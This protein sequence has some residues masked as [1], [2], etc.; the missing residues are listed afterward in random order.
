MKKNIYSLI[1]GIA[2]LVLMTVAVSCSREPVLDTTEKGDPLMISP[3]LVDLKSNVFTS[4]A[5]DT[6]NDAQ[7][8]ENKVN[9]LDVFFFKTSDYSF[10]K[11]YHITTEGGMVSYGGKEGYLLTHDW[12]KDGFAKNTAYTVL[13]IANST[14]ET[15]TS[16]T[17]DS[18]ITLA[19]LK[20]LYVEDADIYKRQGSEDN[21]TYTTSKAFLMNAQ[22]DWSITTSG[23][24]LVNDNTISLERAAVKFI[25]D[26]SLS[27]GFAERLA[28]DHKKYGQPSWK[29]VNF[30]SRAA[31][32]PGGTVP[33]DKLVTRGSGKY[34]AVVPGEQ[35]GHYTIVT[36][37][38]PQSW[39]R[40]TIPSEAPSILLSFPEIDE[41]DDPEN[42]A[43]ASYHY[44][45][46]PLCQTP[47]TGTATTVRN[48]LYKV[49]AIISSHGSSEAITASSLDV[50]YEVMPWGA[51]SS[52][53][54]EAEALDYLV[55]TPTKIS[56]KGEQANSATIKY[57]AS[58]NVIIKE[59]SI[60]AY[61][62]DKTGAEVEV[63]NDFSVG[64]P[65]N[66]TVQISSTMPSNGTFRTLEFTLQLENRDLE[67]IIQIRHYPTDFIT[68]LVGSYSTYDLD[69]WAKPGISGY[70][71]S[72]L[73]GTFQFK[74]ITIP[75]SGSN[76]S[77]T[78][79]WSIEPGFMPKY[80]TTTDD[81]QYSM[82]NITAIY[83]L[84]PNG[85]TSRHL[86]NGTTYVDY[87]NNRMY[88]LQLTSAS[89][90]YIIGYPRLSSATQT[91][92]GETITYH[93]SN[94]NV[95]SPA[96]MLCS[97]LGN[98]NG[99]TSSFINAALHCALYKEVTVDGVEY[100]GW[101][102]PTKQ[103]IN[104]MLEKQG[105]TN[106][107]SDII[108]RILPSKYYWTLDG[109][110]A[111]NPSTTDSSDNTYT[112]CVRDLTPEELAAI[113]QFE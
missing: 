9:R 56:L 112:R 99:K 3:A 79:K 25:A 8:N 71:N 35:T 29:Y 80:Y 51:T 43:K 82:N 33:T 6:P 46:I 13:V 22:V 44:Y 68:S 59:G 81:P 28:T 92:S 20:A 5:D 102:L 49:K 62:I 63:T 103:E 54:V 93:S 64:T 113:N 78:Q 57:Y 105:T 41:D 21:E 60:R 36:Y 91:I 17:D 15:I 42:P 85:Q 98:T 110:R 26:I 95:I 66:G 11:A 94:D 39:T 58:G 72:V 90:S 19:G 65:S 70:N 86:G 37:A 30:N 7:F 1:V 75:R 89:D 109:S 14:N 18:G 27:D 76:L 55:A 53:E 40:E 84:N 104:Y 52:A 73:D 45:Y 69:S 96:F 61:F 2:S 24:Q 111:Q 83:L 47:N 23:T 16:A 101:R 48:N 38:Y 12:L 97:H 50:N 88:V 106:Q 32:V 31:E 87:R 100:T 4:R 108:V 10:V 67:Q 74:N 34:L 77:N 107:P